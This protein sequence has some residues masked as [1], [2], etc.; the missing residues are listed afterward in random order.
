MQQVVLNIFLNELANLNLMENISI[1]VR[2]TITKI[3]KPLGNESYFFVSH[4][5]EKT[6]TTYF[7]ANF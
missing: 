7:S 4:L 6:T 3:S 2:Q 5:Y 1:F